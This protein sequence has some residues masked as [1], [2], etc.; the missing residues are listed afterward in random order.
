MSHHYSK[1]KIDIA[2][3]V[4]LVFLLAFLVSVDPTGGIQGLFITEPSRLSI[5]DIKITEVAWHEHNNPTNDFNE[6]IELYN[7]TGNPISLNN[8]YITDKDDF[9]FKLSGFTIPAY[10]YFLIADYSPNGLAPDYSTAQNPGASFTSN[11]PVTGLDL[12]EEGDDIFL[13]KGDPKQSGSIKLDA[14]AYYKTASG[15]EV[16]TENDDETKL[17]YTNNDNTY[18][19]FERLWPTSDTNTKDDWHLLSPAESSPS[20]SQTYFFTNYDSDYALSDWDETTCHYTYCTDPTNTDTDN[21]GT[22]DGTEIFIC[23]TDPTN[24]NDDKAC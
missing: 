14:V 2:I 16:E 8:Y 17:I 11:N 15:W 12:D 1:R 20:T 6:F 3:I 13:Y 7:P 24:S 4:F 19:S 21:G 18:G 23:R 22:D 9:I 10:S 5:N